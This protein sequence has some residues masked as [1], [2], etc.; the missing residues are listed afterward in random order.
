VKALLATALEDGAMRLNPAAGLRLLPAASETGEEKIKALTEAEVAAILAHVPELAGNAR[1][2]LFFEFLV[3]S[4]CRIGEAVEA[5]WSDIDLGERWLHVRRRYYKGRVGLPKG[6]K[7][8][9]VRLTEQMA[10]SLWRLRA[11]T[12]AGDD[13]PIFLSEKGL[14]IDQSNWMSRILKPAAANAGL[15]EWIEK[16]G[17]AD[18]AESWVGFHTFRHTAATVRFRNG[19][20]AVQVQKFL[21]HSDPGFT[22]RRYVHLLPEDLPEPAFLDGLT[23]SVAGDTLATSRG[24]TSRNRVSTLLVETPAHEPE[25]LGGVR[26]VSAA[27]ASS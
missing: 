14:R 20:N 3:H 6:S 10:R 24:E 18:R 26:P 2:R 25:S 15:G 12:R 13:D 23:A 8:R 7:T 9:K 11:E 19:W 1:P 21:G 27:A 17:R 4:G 5:R 22:L 16:L